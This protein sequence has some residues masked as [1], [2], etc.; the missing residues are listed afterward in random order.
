MVTYIIT[1]PCYIIDHKDWGKLCGN[2]DSSKKNW[3]DEFNN[4]VAKFLEEATGHKAWCSNT[5]F[6]DWANSISGPT[7]LPNHEV[8]GADS[9][10]VCVLR[11]TKEIE[12]IIT[13]R[14]LGNWCYALFEMNEDIDV[15]IDKTD[16]HWYVLTI[17]D[18]EHTVTTEAAE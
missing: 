5:G 1:D 6:G 17:T 9:G 16:P 8:F 10:S 14:D 3:I 15:K 11:Y 2:I 13:Y 12:D 4:D 7:V 18:G